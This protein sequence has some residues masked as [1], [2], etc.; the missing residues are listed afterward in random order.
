MSKDGRIK[1]TYNRDEALYEPHIKV[2]ERKAGVK[3]FYILYQSNYFLGKA[4][5]KMERS[6]RLIIISHNYKRY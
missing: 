5:N 3:S 1:T 2:M 4:L 6:K